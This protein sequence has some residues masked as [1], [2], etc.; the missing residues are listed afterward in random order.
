MGEWIPDRQREWL[1]KVWT[2]NKK[3]SLG[4]EVVTRAGALWAGTGVGY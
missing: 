1:L 4:T 3:H 2:R